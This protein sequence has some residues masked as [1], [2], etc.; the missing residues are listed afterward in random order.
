MQV[1]DGIH[2]V[3]GIRFSNVYVVEAG[4]GL[5]LVDTGTPGRTKRICRYIETMGRHPCELRHIV[6][7]HCDIDHVGSTAALKARTGAEVAMH[8]ADAAVFTMT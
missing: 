8:E 7:T 3:D 1:A 4:D 5:L 6:L 2:W